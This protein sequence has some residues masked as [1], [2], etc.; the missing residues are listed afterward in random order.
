MHLHLGQTFILYIRDAAEGTGD[1][2]KEEI[3]ASL[4]DVKPSDQ[5]IHATA[6][7]SVT[8]ARRVTAAP[9]VPGFIPPIHTYSVRHAEE[10][11]FKRKG[12][13]WRSPLKENMPIVKRKRL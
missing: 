10:E 2:K 7:P 12:V 13:E 5:V 1:V 3:E 6:H 8:L 4:T 9:R 11:D